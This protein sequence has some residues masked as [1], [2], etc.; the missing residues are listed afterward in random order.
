MIVG[1]LSPALLDMSEYAAPYNKIEGFENPDMQHVFNSLLTITPAPASS[2]RT[3]SGSRSGSGSGACPPNPGQ[4]P[5]SISETN[6]PAAP[7]SF[8]K[9]MLIQQRE[10]TK[11]LMNTAKRIGP[12]TQKVVQMEQAYSTAFENDLQAALPD[13]GGTLQ[14]FVLL[15]FLVSYGAL[16]LVSTIMTYVITGSIKNALG[17]FAAFIF[18]GIIATSLLARL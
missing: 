2:R 1:N 10:A 9:T 11:A 5:L 14:G 16:T 3:S 8:L 17:I 18:A 7:T 6:E 15:F 13:V 4:T 12:A